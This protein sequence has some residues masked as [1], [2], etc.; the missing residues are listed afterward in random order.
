M[1]PEIK[2]EAQIN[3][4]M[5]RRQL[6]LLMIDRLCKKFEFTKPEPGKPIADYEPKMK[7]ALR[8]LA[9]ES[10]IPYK[11]VK[12]LYFGTVSARL[13]EIADIGFHLG[14]A[15][16]VK[17][18]PTA[19]KPRPLKNNPWK[20]L[21]SIVSRILTNYDGW[22]VGSAAN[23][24]NDD[25]RDFDLMIPHH[26]WHDAAAAMPTDARLNSWNGVKFNDPDSGK[27]I[28]CWPGDLSWFATIPGFTYAYHPRTG[29]LIH[30]SGA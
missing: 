20:K 5:L 6:R 2:L 4:L 11:R 16:H 25:P 18:E 29:T 12:A 30:R 1:D 10:G 8:W 9:N 15:V 22:L 27:E 21:P 13:D 3:D 17:T 28:D 7:E 19:P 14:A 24:A 26:R 23:P